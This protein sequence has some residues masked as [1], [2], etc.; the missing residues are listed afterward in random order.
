MECFTL[1]ALETDLEWELHKEILL[2]SALFV[3]CEDTEEAELD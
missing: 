1:D 3:T 2:Q